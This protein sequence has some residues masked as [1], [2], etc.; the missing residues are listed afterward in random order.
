MA[1]HIA[2]DPVPIATLAASCGAEPGA[3]ARVLR[4]LA[5]H[6]V[7]AERGRWL[8]A[9]TASLIEARAV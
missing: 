6:D 1:D 2:D 7:F 8:G 3:L 4:L 9:H 5:A